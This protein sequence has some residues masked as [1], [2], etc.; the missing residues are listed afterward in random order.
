M[1]QVSSLDA[2]VFDEAYFADPYAKY[3]ELHAT[4]CPVFRTETPEG[5][6][7]WL[8]TGH[9]EV[10]AAL[11]DLRLSRRLDNA[12]ADYR[13]LPFP[14]EF[15]AKSVVTEDPPEH[16]RLRHVL[17]QAFSPRSISRLRPR[18]EAVAAALVDAIKAKGS[19]DLVTDLAIPLPLTI[20]AEMLGI[21]ARHQADFHRWGDGMLS[22]DTETRRESSARMLQFLVDQLRGKAAEPGDDML[23]Y[24]LNSR[25]EEG[26]PLDPQEVVGLAMVMLV[27]GYDT[28]VGM[29]GAT[30][31]GLLR[32]PERYSAL[33]AEPQL[34]PEVI[35]EYL[36]LYGTVH[37]GVRRFAAQ[38]LEIGS[39]KIP[40]GDVVLLSLGAA[41]R[42]PERYPD[43]DTAD[44]GRQSRSSHLAFGLGPHVC[45]G[46]ELARIEISAAVQAAMTGLPGLRLAVP[47]EQVSWRRAYFIRVPLTLPVVF[48]APVGG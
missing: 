21:D 42:D 19:A 33:L 27:G 34:L 48:D 6:P 36:R 46:N 16:T 43:P 30:L 20:I 14:S 9:E 7:A 29:I 28:S 13:R 26:N 44:F 22:L 12:G 2:V 3:A 1:D 18:V 8:I 17:N 40:A 24:W 47:E 35:E 45:P 37:T 38:D 41:D 31:Y 32:E 5:V 4:G 23:T 39:Q 15:T 11:K 10:R 25:D